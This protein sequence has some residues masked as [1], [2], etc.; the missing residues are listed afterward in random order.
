MV[1]KKIIII[2]LFSAVIGLQGMRTKEQPKKQ[3]KTL[4]Q[5]R[6]EVIGERNK[7]QKNIE[8]VCQEIKRSNPSV[9]IVDSGANKNNNK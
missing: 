8:K 1:M 5:L 4:E 7:C 3:I 2:G 9:T 6:E